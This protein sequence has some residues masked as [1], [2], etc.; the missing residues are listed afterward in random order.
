MPRGTIARFHRKTRDITIE[1]WPRWSDPSKSG[2]EQ[3][4][5]WP[6]TI[7]QEDNY[8]RAPI[9]YLPTLEI[10]GQEDPV[11]QVIDEDFGEVVYTLRINGTSWRPK[12]FKEGTYTIKVGE[13]DS[14]KV[15]QNV[16]SVGPDEQ[17][18][19]TVDFPR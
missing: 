5:D 8:P 9:A 13:G 1:C 3:Y 7:N 6:I 18:T 19:L 2:A 14:V 10:T 11:V 4:P 12:V 17:P 16:E 15:F